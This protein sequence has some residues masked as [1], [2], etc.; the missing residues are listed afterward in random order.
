VI[1]WA[2]DRVARGVRHFLEGLNRLD[3][4]GIEFVSFRE[5]L[6]SG[7]PLGRAVM[8][9]VSALAELERNLINAIIERGSRRP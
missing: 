3:H 7:G 2:A 1:V 9:I 6:D 8:V 5:K 4:L